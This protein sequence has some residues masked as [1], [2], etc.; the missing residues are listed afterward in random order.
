MPKFKRKKDPVKAAVKKR[1]A[2]KKTTT[3]DVSQDVRMKKLE[4][5]VKSLSAASAGYQIIEQGA[6]AIATMEGVAPSAPIQNYLLNRLYPVNTAVSAALP[7]ASARVGAFVSNRVITLRYQVW[8]PPASTTE[9]Y[10]DGYCDVRV[11]AFCVKKPTNQSATGVSMQG[12]SSALNIFN[13]LLLITPTNA[14]TYVMTQHD[15]MSFKQQNLTNIQVYYDKIHKLSLQGPVNEEGPSNDK[16]MARGFIKIIPKKKN[17][18][19]KYND[20]DTNSVDT[21]IDISE[22]AFYVATF[23]NAG[24]AAPAPILPHFW[25]KGIYKFTQ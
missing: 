25:M 6:T 2:A 16:F 20:T 19:T 10:P 22:N 24:L 17:Q 1:N 12:G 14:A 21:A 13:D 15:I 8:M 23:C 3:K 9:Y 18:V 4:K 7:E 11:V 5:K